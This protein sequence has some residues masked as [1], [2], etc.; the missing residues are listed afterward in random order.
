MERNNT[1]GAKREEQEKKTLF[2][3]KAVSV[4]SMI[5]TLIRFENLSLIE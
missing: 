4:N 1:K 2:F 3:P 5:K